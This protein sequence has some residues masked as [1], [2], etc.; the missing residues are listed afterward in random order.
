MCEIKGLRVEDGDL[1][2]TVVPKSAEGFV[3]GDSEMDIRV[4]LNS[5]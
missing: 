1:K 2:G 5:F 3:S 4:N